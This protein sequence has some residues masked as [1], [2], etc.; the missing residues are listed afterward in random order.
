MEKLAIRADGGQIIGMG[1]VMRCME[2]AKE[3]K[4]R[5]IEVLFISKYSKEVNEILENNCIDFININ[6]DDLEEELEEV[7]KIIL[8]EKIDTILTDSY[9]LSDKYLLE[10]KKYV[11]TLISIDD[12]SLYYYPSDFIINGNIYANG[13]DYKII[14]NKSKLLLGTEYTILRDEFQNEFNY[15]VN[16]QVKNILITMG[17]SDIND[18]TPFVLDS[19]KEIDVNINVIIGKSFK[20]IDK[21]KSI[22]KGNKNINLIYNPSNISE[23]MKNT[24]IAISAS[25]STVYEL[26]VIGVPTILIIQ[27]KNQENIAYELDKNNIMIN[28]GYFYNINKRDILLIV[29]NLMNNF[30]KR[31]SMSKSTKYLISSYGVKNIVNYILK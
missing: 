16:E 23:I 18:F 11:D 22:A 13:L 8:E 20:C 21:I 2:L 25:G 3:F 29:E 10:L 7:K 5:S 14:N 26:G 31:I 24:D 30:S 28:L 12:N 19:I 17:G 15:I 4:H 1:H 6:S 27:A 9:F